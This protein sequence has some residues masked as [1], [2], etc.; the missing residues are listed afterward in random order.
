[1]GAESDR[2]GRLGGHGVALLVVGALGWKFR[3]QHESDWGIDAIIEIA[4][5]D[6]PIGRLIA[7]Q[8]KSGIAAISD[9]PQWEVDH[10]WREAS[11]LTLA[12][13]SDTSSGRALRSGISGGILAACRRGHR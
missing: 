1:M 2:V 11:P 13:I 12:G 6:R 7:L 5:D 3:E 9:E 4:E 10:V 8:I